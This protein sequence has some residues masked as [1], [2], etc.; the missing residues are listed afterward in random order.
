MNASSDLLGLG[1]G[2]NLKTNQ[3]ILH[4]YTLWT[5]VVAAFFHLIPA[6]I[7]YGYPW[8]YSEV[9]GNILILVNAIMSLKLSFHSS[10]LLHDMEMLSCVEI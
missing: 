1:T 2:A 7:Q 8:W 10:Y 9:G 6:M 5:S 3:E 4:N